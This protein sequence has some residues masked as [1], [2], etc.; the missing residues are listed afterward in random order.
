MDE[1]IKVTVWRFCSTFHMILYSSSL[2]LLTCMTF[3]ESAAHIHSC[4]GGPCVGFSKLHI[5][6]SLLFFTF[7]LHP[8]QTALYAIAT[9][10]RSLHY[11]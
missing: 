1:T 9:I 2:R 6:L 11:H 3:F 4:L 7:L 8:T 5:P 10:I